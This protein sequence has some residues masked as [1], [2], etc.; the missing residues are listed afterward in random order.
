[1]KTE[2]KS[3]VRF[4]KDSAAMEKELSKYI[5]D[6]EKKS[7][8]LQNIKWVSDLCSEGKLE[9]AKTRAKAFGHDGESYSEI[10]KAFEFF[11]AMRCR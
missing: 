9:L 4:F 5:P 2:Y 8:F 10:Y 7:V 11:E 1:M 3:A 6:Y